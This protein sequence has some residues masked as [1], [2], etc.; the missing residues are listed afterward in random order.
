MLQQKDLTPEWLA[1]WLQ[2]L[3]RDV[4]LAHALRAKA[5]Q[6]TEAVEVMVEACEAL[7]T[8]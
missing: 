1:H 6:K 4:L 2:S 3:D 5:M 7:V 8:V